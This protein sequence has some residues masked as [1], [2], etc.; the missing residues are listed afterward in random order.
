MG[1]VN[2]LW[3]FPP[4][5]LAIV[6]LIVLPKFKQG[7][8]TQESV[9]KAIPVKVIKTVRLPFSPKVSGYGMT[10]PG[11]T[12]NAISEV[13]AKVS[14]ISEQL[15][16]GNIIA[17]DTHLISLDDTSYQLNLK[18]ILAQINLLQIKI[19]ATDNNLVIEQKRYQSLEKEVQRKQKL[20]KKGTLTQSN[21]DEATRNLLALEL[22][23]QNQKNNLELQKAELEVYQLQKAQA[24]LEIDHTKIFAPMDIRV[25]ELNV[26]LHQYV[27][28]GQNLVSADGIDQVEIEARIPIGQLKPLL[29]SKNDGMSDSSVTEKTPGALK[30]EANVILK[31]A[32]HEIN[33]PAKV[34]RVSGLI[35]QATQTIGVVVTIDNPYQM[36]QPGKRPP[37]IRNTLVKV[38][39]KKQGKGEPIIIPQSAF[40]Q[41][42][43]YLLNNENRLKI[44]KVKPMFKQGNLVIIN[45]GLEEDETLVISKLIP[46]IEGML[47]E[48]IKDKKAMQKL[49]MEALGQKMKKGQSK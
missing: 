8:K 2:K 33:W 7:P 39:L 19:R 13:S 32:T 36:A 46:A 29:A 49:K 27:N 45:K 48:P 18:Q 17:K 40:Q 34:N 4:I 28:K 25:T 47:L 14:W 24:E 9:E 10:R 15:K 22:A 44:A 1:K 41:G 37:L 5:A 31:T 6:I 23:I 43:V 30:L 12:W 3:I 16:A 35:D 26:Q 42:K 38:E 11:N 20:F 21:Y